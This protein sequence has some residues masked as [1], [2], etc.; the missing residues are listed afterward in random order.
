MRPPNVPPITPPAACSPA[1][2]ATPPQAAIA[3]I[4]MK[5]EPMMNP[6]TAAERVEIATALVIA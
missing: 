1:Q 2:P 6:A 5:N 3:G 4:G